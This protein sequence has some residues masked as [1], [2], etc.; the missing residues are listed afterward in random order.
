MAGG[1]HDPAIHALVK[2]R[3]IDFLGPALPDVQ[4]IHAGITQA[5]DQCRADLRTAQANIVADHDGA[6]RNHLDIGSPYAVG[7][8]GV[9]LVGNPATDI[10]GLEA[11]EFCAHIRTLTYRKPDGSL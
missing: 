7:D 4:H 1:D 3:E 2:S 10:V 5:F 9:Q 8:F 6:R 11:F